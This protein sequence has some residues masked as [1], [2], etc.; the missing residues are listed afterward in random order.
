[1]FSAV[2]PYGYD[3]GQ[4]DLGI[5]R[6]PKSVK[7]FLDKMRDKLEWCIPKETMHF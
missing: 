4:Q 2:R 7:R 6:I 5:K 1:M 3:N